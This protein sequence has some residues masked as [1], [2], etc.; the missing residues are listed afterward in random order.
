MG[1]KYK[2]RA[3]GAYPGRGV[4][5]GSPSR[6]PTYDLVGSYAEIKCKF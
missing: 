1:I 3:R 4:D 6:D 5:L 2:A